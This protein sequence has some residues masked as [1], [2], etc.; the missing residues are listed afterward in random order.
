M[1]SAVRRGRNRNLHHFAVPAREAG[2][3][4][5]DETRHD[6]VEPI[7]LRASLRAAV[8]QRRVGSGGAD[9]EV[10]LAVIFDIAVDAAA[11]VAAIPERIV[12][13]VIEGRTEPV[14]WIE[15]P[16]AA[17]EERIAVERIR[18]DPNLAAVDTVAQLNGHRRA[19][20]AGGRSVAAGLELLGDDSG[21]ALEFEPAIRR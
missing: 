13:A 11:A 20:R 5:F 4:S 3:Q 10:D 12:P 19:L 9:V 6:H 2:E 17:I 8:E 1:A 7:G 18:L 14:P 21:I 15:E 16:T